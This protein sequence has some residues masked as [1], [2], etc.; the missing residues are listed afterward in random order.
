MFGGKKKIKLT[1]VYHIV[2]LN[3]LLSN[4]QFSLMNYSLLI[5]NW[6]LGSVSENVPTFWTLSL[7]R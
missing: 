3:Y 4:C 5:V 1:V 7:L 6:S 2:N